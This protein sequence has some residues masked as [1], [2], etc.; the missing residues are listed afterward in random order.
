MEP[1]ITQLQVYSFCLRSCTCVM[2][3][4]TTG[5][6][7]CACAYIAF[8]V[9]TRNKITPISSLNYGWCSEYLFSFVC[10]FFRSRVR[11]FFSVRYV[12]F[13]QFLRCEFFVYFPGVSSSEVCECPCRLLIGPCSG[14]C[15]KCYSD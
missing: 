1:K 13:G 9:N 8:V 4:L 14:S 12:N 7:A 10:A 2:G 5:R 11:F 6:Y 3:V 15:Q